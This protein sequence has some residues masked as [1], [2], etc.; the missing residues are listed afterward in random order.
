[1]ERD[2][3]IVEIG[4]LIAG[5]RKLSALPWDRYALVAYYDGD[6]SKLNGFRYQG[7]AAGEPA[8]PESTDIDDRLDDLREATRVEGRE[9]WQA[10]VFRIERE[11]A[12]ATVDFEYEH[13]EKWRVTPATVAEVAARARPA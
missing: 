6:V 2:A 5:D 3:L 13:P 4:R 1:M 10:C 8:T 11:S 12:K 7:D 9:P